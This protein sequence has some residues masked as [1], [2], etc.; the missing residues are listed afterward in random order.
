MQR[1]EFRAMGSG[2]LAVLE[3][4]DNRAR[5]AL[6]EV[7]RWF[8][9]WESHLSRFRPESEL[10]QLNSASGQWVSVSPV[11]WDVLSAARLLERLSDGLVTP[12]LQGALEGYG[13]DR[14]FELVET[15]SSHPRWG[16]DPG[17]RLGRLDMEI[18][19]IRRRV[20]FGAGTILDL[21]GVA[22]GW[23]ADRALARLSKFGPGLVD[24][25]GDIA[26][27]S[28][29]APNGTWPIG[30]TDPR[31][32]ETT[33]ELL[34]LRSRAVATSGRDVHRWRQGGA[35]RHH[36]ID[37]RTGEPARSEVLTATAIAPTAVEAEMAAKCALILG[38]REGTAWLDAR[39]DY[40]GLLA[41]EDGQAVYSQGM[42]SFCWR[43]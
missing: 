37:P 7:P 25:A 32:P 43:G 10:N 24:A 19:P 38:A 39:P 21:G 1:I 35:W 5:R 29:N 22:K 15:M 36:I 16:R 31:A 14:S 23:A 13:Y 30:V 27:S 8:E 28:P 20:R 11:L 4:E 41:L 33:I 2:M 3:S 34:M 17:G 42:E 26:V 18:D 12:A 6:N 40:Y 9:S